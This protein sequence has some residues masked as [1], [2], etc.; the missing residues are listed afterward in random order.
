ME[1]LRRSFLKVFSGDMPQKIE[2]FFK[3][4]KLIGKVLR[5]RAKI[6]VPIDNRIVMVIYQYKDES[7]LSVVFQHRQYG[8]N[9]DQ[10]KW[11]KIEGDHVY[12]VKKQM[13]FLKYWGLDI[14][15]VNTKLEDYVL[16]KV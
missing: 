7:K 6:Y 10:N 11:I 15:Y 13:R 1:S 12:Q 2:K 4:V 8:F 3:N 9:S 14:D 5:D 16:E